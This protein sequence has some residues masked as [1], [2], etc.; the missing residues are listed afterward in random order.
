MKAEIGKKYRHYKGNEYQVVAIA[1]S[2]ENIEE[3]LV[4]YQDLSDLAKVWARP[5]AMFEEEVEVGGKRVP[6]FAP[7]E[8]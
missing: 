8:D 3:E 7:L 1:R 5:R 4:V 2:S 6:R